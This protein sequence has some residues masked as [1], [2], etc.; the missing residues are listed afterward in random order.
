MWV[1]ETLKEL[2]QE[3][4]AQIAEI[5]IRKLLRVQA[6]RWGSPQTMQAF[7]GHCKDFGFCSHGTGEVVRGSE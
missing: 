6:G 4:Q 3:E 2:K 1:P 5:E 7:V